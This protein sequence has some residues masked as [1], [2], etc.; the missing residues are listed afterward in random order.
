MQFRTWLS[1]TE[2][3]SQDSLF[4]QT[5][6]SG[7][8]PK[9][10]TNAG[11]AK[12]SDGWLRGKGQSAGTT[13]WMKKKMQKES[14]FYEDINTDPYERVAKEFCYLLDTRPGS[15]GENSDRTKMDQEALKLMHRYF[16]KGEVDWHRI[17]EVSKNYLLT[18]YRNYS[19]EYI[20]TQEAKL[21]A[22]L[23]YIPRYFGGG[24]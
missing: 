8:G 13:L 18:L 23:A 24:H 6:K 17:E 22:M 12:P 4:M 21:D 7:L 5:Q 20:K 3:Q 14:A 11:R 2:N 10:S 1:L 16:Q 19:E 9:P 15:L